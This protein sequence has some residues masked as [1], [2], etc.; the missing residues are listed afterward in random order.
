MGAILTGPGLV[1]KEWRSEHVR[2]KLARHV[3]NDG[4]A[5][6]RSGRRSPDPVVVHGISERSGDA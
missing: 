2:D 6:K 1:V 4:A 3:G 5:W